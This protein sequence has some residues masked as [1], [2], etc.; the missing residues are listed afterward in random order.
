MRNHRQQHDGM[1]RYHVTCAISCGFPPLYRL[2]RTRRG[3]WTVARELATVEQP[4]VKPGTKFCKTTKSFHRH[5][6]NRL[7]TLFHLPE[8]KNL[9]IFRCK[10][11]TAHLGCVVATE[12]PQV[13]M[14][15]H[16]YLVR[17][18]R[19]THTDSSADG[20]TDTHTRTDVFNFTL[21]VKRPL[22]GHK[23]QK[24]SVGNHHLA[25]KTVVKIT[26]VVKLISGTITTLSVTW[27]KM[28]SFWLIMQI[29][30]F[31]QKQSEA[32]SDIFI[33]LKFK[34]HGCNWLIVWEDEDWWPRTCRMVFV[35]LDC[36][37]LCHMSSMVNVFNKLSM[38]KPVLQD[39]GKW[40][41]ASCPPSLGVTRC[42]WY[43]S[44]AQK[45]N[46][47]W[48]WWFWFFFAGL[49]G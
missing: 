7:K 2:P 1:G 18:D 30:Y 39:I 40:E 38:L 16:G 48:L 36:A 3:P 5:S 32:I 45:K 4:Q 14:G 24:T 29:N 27:P 6:K 34:T 43:A 23:K 46:E 26:A 41:V 20:R 8:I 35:S 9:A 33:F 49:V 17:T 47:R 13:P 44:I 25:L 15:I 37:R 42:I 10:T 21:Y 31:V 12:K 22:R 28:L 11:S 19:H